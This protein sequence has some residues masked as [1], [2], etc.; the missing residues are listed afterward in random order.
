MK[1]SRTQR[2]LLIKAHI[3][4]LSDRRENKIRALVTV[5]PPRKIHAMKTL[6]PTTRRVPV[7]QLQST[8]DDTVALVVPQPSELVS[9]SSDVMALPQV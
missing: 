3:G 1:G 7:V 4:I 8:R 5:W 2:A 6:S 9:A